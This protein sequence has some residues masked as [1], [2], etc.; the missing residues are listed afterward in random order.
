MNENDG[1]KKSRER[2]IE[3][4]KIAAALL[5]MGIFAILCILHFSGEL[6]N[7]RLSRVEG[8]SHLS[9][10]IERFTKILIDKINDTLVNMLVVEPFEKHVSL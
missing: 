7:G 10:E 1:E 4:Y 2:E 8:L 9:A 3:N 6:I 5:A